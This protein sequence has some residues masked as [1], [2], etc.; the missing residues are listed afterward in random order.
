MKTNKNY[1]T[2]FSQQFPVTCNS[3]YI[4]PGS[5]FVAIAGHQHDG[6]KYIQQAINQG[7]TTILVEKTYQERVQSLVIQNQQISFIYVDNARKAL[8]QYASHALGNPAAQLTLIG[9]TGTK[10]KTTTS[11]LIEHLLRAQGYK[12]ALLGSIKN[13][14]LDE[15]EP[16]TLTTPES[17][18]L[19]MFFAECV[20]KGVQYVVME[21]SSQALSLY[22]VYGISFDIACFTNLDTDHMDFY[23][24][25]DDYFHAKMLLFKQVKPNGSLII[26][27]DNEWSQKAIQQAALTKTTDQRLVTF[28]QAEQKKSLC[29]HHTQVIYTIT[30][31]TLDGLKLTF[32]WE[33]KNVQL[34]IPSMFGTFNASNALMA[35]LSCLERGLQP[36]SIEKALTEFPGVP[37][38]LQMHRLA[39]GAQAFVDF[40]HNATSFKNVLSVLR[41]IT[42]HL[43]V[44]FGCGGDKD[45]TRRPAMGYLA[46]QY[47]DLIILTDDNPRSEDRL[48]IICDILQGIPEE[49]R[50][51]VICEPDRRKA[52]AFAVQHSHQSSVIA[53]LGKG[54]E[55]YY[56]IKNE[57][58]YFSDFEEIQKF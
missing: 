38:R 20:R 4:G 50:T 25:L 22:R 40:A 17:D 15:E 52:I 37:G 42:P 9:I 6:H 43:I 45:K 51:K 19:H 36:S 57:K 47:A 11:Y 26:N 18:Y 14:I 54:H 13:K 56:L 44:V 55:T 39:N 10:G 30:Q 28:S 16:N 12:T 5:T 49:Q 46:S 8:A 23:T 41:S 3:K 7:A 29:H 32:S 24:N 31:N 33:T 27:Y 2:L 58:I 48:A 35:T 53:L 21:V 34:T 1:T